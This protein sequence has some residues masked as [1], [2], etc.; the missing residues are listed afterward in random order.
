M[1]L[2][3]SHMRNAVSHPGGRVSAGV[4]TAMDRSRKSTK[5]VPRR[6]RRMSLDRLQATAVRRAY[7][8]IE[9]LIVIVLITI[10][11]GLTL[12]TIGDSKE[13]RLREAARLLAA[14]IEFAQSESIAH[15]GDNDRRVV[16]FDTTNNRYWIAPRSDTSVAAAVTDIVIQAPF[17]VQ[18]GAGRAASLH[19]VTLQSVSV[20]TNDELRLDPY[21][22]PEQGSDATVTLQ[23]GPATMTVTVDGST[24]EVSV[25]SP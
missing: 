14:D 20:G 16:A 22:V 9:L 4:R 8:L 15:P 25:S 10:A 5:P 12:P 6:Q 21:G 1:E 7:T 11:F 23:C 3:R 19:G 24:G 17:V 18:F 2:Q 13:L